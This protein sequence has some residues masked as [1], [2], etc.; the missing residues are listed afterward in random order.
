ML[1]NKME[2]TYPITREQLRKYG[3][4]YRNQQKE[5]LIQTCVDYISNKIIQSVMPVGNPYGHLQNSKAVSCEILISELI[6]MRTN[7]SDVY[8]AVR[9][10]PFD[11]YFV[12]ILER[13]KQRFPDCTFTQDPAKKYLFVDWS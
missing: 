9:D 3:D 10:G 6:N 7:K 13:V 4:V 8:M 5:F 12:Q 11:P 2:P 1:P